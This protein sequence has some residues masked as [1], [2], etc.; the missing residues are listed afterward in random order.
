MK[1][2]RIILAVTATSLFAGCAP[3]I[4]TRTVTVTTFPNGSK[5]TIERKELMQRF[6]T[7]QIA[8][9]DDVINSCAK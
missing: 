6:I 7:P 9:T 4:A 2:I 3:T 8:S 5:E 1:A